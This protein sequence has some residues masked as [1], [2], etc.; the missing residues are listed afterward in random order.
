MTSA[1]AAGETT[2]IPQAATREQAWWKWLAIFFAVAWAVTLILLFRRPGRTPEQNEDSLK[3]AQ[4]TVKAATS[5]VIK[6]ANN[7]DAAATKTALIEWA[8]VFY[9]D[10]ELTNL[11]Q[12][13]KHCSAQLG[14]QIRELNESLYSPEKNGWNGTE[15]VKLFKQEQELAKAQ[16]GGKQSA[17]KPLYSG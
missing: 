6:H 16:T 17:L 1:P 11:S 14:L 2:S 10:S 12:I 15:L 4:I 3:T 5:A 9:N 7:N 8:Q 13:I